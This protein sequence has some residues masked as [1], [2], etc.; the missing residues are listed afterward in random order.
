M[1]KGFNIALLNKSFSKFGDQEHK[2]T[3]L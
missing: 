3:T 1:V 2:M